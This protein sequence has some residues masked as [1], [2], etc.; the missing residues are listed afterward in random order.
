MPL[1]PPVTTTTPRSVRSI[2]A[3]VVA[4]LN[5]GAVVLDDRVPTVRPLP[6]RQLVARC[7][8]RGA[9]LARAAV[10]GEVAIIISRHSVDC[11]PPG[12][13]AS[14][15]GVDGSVLQLRQILLNFCGA[16][17]DLLTGYF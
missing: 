4:G 1:A 9:G 8:R 11:S 17:G 10:A 6:G 3:T 5:R 16:E 12:V 7:R 14:R 13:L 2:A 15:C